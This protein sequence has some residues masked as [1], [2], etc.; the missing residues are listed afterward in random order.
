[1]NFWNKH[2]L[3]L[4]HLRKEAIKV[5]EEF[6]VRHNPKEKNYYTK[7]NSLINKKIGKQTDVLFKMFVV[8]STQEIC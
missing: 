2:D 1:M 8:K 6:E 7:L 3:I 5:R 4:S